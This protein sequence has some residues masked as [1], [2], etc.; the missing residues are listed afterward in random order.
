MVT[1]SRLSPFANTKLKREKKDFRKRVDLKSSSKP[2]PSGHKLLYL[3]FS[4]IDAP[5]YQKKALLPVKKLK[6]SLL[7]NS[8]LRRT[9]WCYCI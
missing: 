1:K 3:W 9:L 5:L 8:E 7:S 4:L 6:D 2:N